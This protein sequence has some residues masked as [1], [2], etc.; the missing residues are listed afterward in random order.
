MAANALNF[1]R[2]HS[3]R[4]ERLHAGVN[5][6]GQFALKALWEKKKPCHADSGDLSLRQQRARPNLQPDE[7]HLHPADIT[8]SYPQ[9]TLWS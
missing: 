8:F 1:K 7:L 3:C 9:A 5:T 2:S 4:C 6:T